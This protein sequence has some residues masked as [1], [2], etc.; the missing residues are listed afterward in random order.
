MARRVAPR[1]SQGER[2]LK[3]KA[4]PPGAPLPS[5][6]QGRDAKGPARSAA[7]SK[8]HAWLERR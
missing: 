1:S 3:T 6:E 8:D 4:A 7:A 5:M 2:A